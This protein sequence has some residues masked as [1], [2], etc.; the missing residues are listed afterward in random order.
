[1]KKPLK[2][3]EK[4]G[5]T[6]VL[7]SRNVWPPLNSAFLD[8]GVL[9]RTHAVYCPA[10]HPKR[11]RRLHI[12]DTRTY[13]PPAGYPVTIDSGRETSYHAL[14]PGTSLSRLSSTTQARSWQRTWSRCGAR[15]RPR[16]T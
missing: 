12:H 11:T 2:M 1:M 3:Q 8:G 5:N 14:T 16:R 13:V 9:H 10:N 4:M 15:Q 7:V 6:W